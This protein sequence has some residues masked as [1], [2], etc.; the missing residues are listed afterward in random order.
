MQRFTQ[1]EAEATAGALN[2]VK[3]MT[4]SVTAPGG[5]DDFFAVRATLTTKKGTASNRYV[6]LR[7][8]ASIVEHLTAVID[9]GASNAKTMRHFR[10]AERGT[11]R[12]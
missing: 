11:R 9:A 4:A 8:V 3:G 5:P 2:A 12:S 1:A 10:A 7:D 6:W